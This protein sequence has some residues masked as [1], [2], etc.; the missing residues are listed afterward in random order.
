MFFPEISFRSSSASNPSLLPDRNTK[1][2]LSGSKQNFQRCLLVSSSS[3]VAS[4]GIHHNTKDSH[5]SHYFSNQISYHEEKMISGKKILKNEKNFPKDFFENM[6][7]KK[8]YRVSQMSNIRT[9]TDSQEMSKLPANYMKRN[10]YL[11]N[12]RTSDI[13]CK[14]AFDLLCKD[15]LTTEGYS[16][17]SINPYADYLKVS[18]HENKKNKSVSQRQIY[19]SSFNKMNEEFIIKNEMNFLLDGK[20]GLDLKKK[21]LKNSFYEKIVNNP[22]LISKSHPLKPLIQEKSQSTQ[23]NSKI[24]TENENEFLDILP[25]VKKTGDFG[26]FIEESKT[27]EKDNWGAMF[28]FYDKNLKVCND[29]KN[30][31]FLKEAGNQA[32]NQ[33]T[34]HFKIISKISKN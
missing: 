13:I 8:N 23:E 34:G 6:K 14:E 12:K 7:Q 28:T 17:L 24:L 21:P 27:K 25:N 16:N 4:E 5:S 2:Y 3:H 19:E 30:K 26:V 1:L 32:V 11:L 20:I 15:K 10:S 22:K 33:K 31:S 18:N 9:E 29:E